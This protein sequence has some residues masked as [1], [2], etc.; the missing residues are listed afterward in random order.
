MSIAETIE[1]MRA[2]ALGCDDATA[3]FPALYTVVTERISDAIDTGTRFK[4]GPRL[5]RFATAFADLHLR[6]RTD[7]SYRPQCW[8]ACWNVADDKSLLIVQHV[9]LGINAHVNH[10]LPIA[11]VATC[12]DAPL[13]SMKDDFY[14]INDVLGETYHEI[15]RSLGRVSGWANAA[16][17]LGG[18]Q[19]FNFSLRV[20]RD[21]AWGTA[22]HLYAKRDD[23]AASA[24]YRKE[25]D[26]VVSVLSY[27]ITQPEKL[28][29]PLI[30]AL[31]R[32]ENKDPRAVARA[33]LGVS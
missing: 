3:Y 26:E 30:W 14:G 2:A 16:A 1:A 9:L 15:I 25:I 32:T 27:M 23:A 5:D 24:D 8:Q 7:L 6:A 28:A 11:T 33:F 21:R 31:R 12:G 20:G 18:G 29:K 10:D 19:L 4:D 13:D 22:Q 17:S